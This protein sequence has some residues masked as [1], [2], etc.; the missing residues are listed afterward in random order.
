MMSVLDSI[1]RYV[2]IFIVSKNE[3]NLKIIFFSY[4]VHTWRMDGQM[5]GHRHTIIDPSQRQAY[6]NGLS[7]TLTS[8]S[9]IIM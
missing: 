1:H 6:K 9:H 3:T 4:H 8:H 2:Q 5:D 7:F